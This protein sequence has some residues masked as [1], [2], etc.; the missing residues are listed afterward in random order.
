MRFFRSVISGVVLSLCFF[1]CKNNQSS[2]NGTKE[3]TVVIG[4]NADFDT[5]LEIATANSDALHVIEEMLFLTLFDLDEELNITPR[6]AKSWQF[7]PDHKIA[8]IA[9]R[10][11]VYWQDGERTTAADV[12]FTW[13]VASDPQTGYPGIN[14]FDQVDS[15]V[16]VDDFTLRCHYKLAY[17]DALYDLRIPVLPKHLLQNIPRAELKQADFNRKPVGNGPYKLKEWRA[18]DRVIFEANENF[19]QGRPNIDRVVFRIVPDEAVLNASL[20]REE[21]DFTPYVAPNR[22]TALEAVPNLYTQTHLDRGYSFLAFNMRRAPF[23]DVKVRQA[24]TGAVDKER[25]LSVLYRRKAQQV[26]G[27]IMPYFSAFNNS[28][29][30]E[31]FSPGSATELLSLS[32]W[33]DADS[34]GWLEKDDKPLKFTM[35]T[36]ADNQ[37]RSDMLAMIQADLKKIGVDA[38]PE[39][40]EMGRLVQDVLQTHDFDAVLLSW[41]TGFTIN[42]TQIWHSDAIE[43]GYNLSGYSNDLVDSLLVAGRKEIDDSRRNE[44]WRAFQKEVSEDAPYVFLF[45]QENTGVVNARVK[46]LQMDVR[47]YLINVESWRIEESEPLAANSPTQ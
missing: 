14:R 21:I 35:K 47:G 42:P 16:A 22:L 3:K 41:K 36:N 20:L 23:Q 9:L 17:A 33:K 6:L 38:Q 25:I 4:L 45:A 12:I 46:N 39:P 30:A 1:S 10:D 27:P 44:I 32:G 2:E 40:L 7:S 18:N 24:I 5:L 31:E 19:Y 37:L 29:S 15:L 13:Q 26:S 43:N 8:T 11:D 34:D 28:S